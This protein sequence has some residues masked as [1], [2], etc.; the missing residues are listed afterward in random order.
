L[1]RGE[2]ISEEIVAKI[3]GFVRF[4]EDYEA[5]A[6]RIRA[7][8]SQPWE[9]AAYVAWLGWGGDTGIE[10]ARGVQEARRAAGE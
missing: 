9:E 5:A 7:G 6:A 8:E 1:A 4:R 3:A 2:P 10:W